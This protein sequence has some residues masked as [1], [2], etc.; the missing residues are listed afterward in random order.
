MENKEIKTQATV[1]PE[2]APDILAKAKANSKLILILSI[3]IFVVLAGALAWFLISQNNAKKSD[4][5]AGEADLYAMKAE[6]SMSAADRQLNDSLALEYYKEA[7][8]MGHKSGNRSKLEVAIR[9]YQKGDYQ[10]ALDYLKDASIGDNLIKAGSYTLM[11]DC[12]VG[13][14]NNA[15]ALKAYDDAIDAADENPAVVPLVLI[16]KANIFRAEKNYEGEYLALK[17][18]LDKYPAY[19]NNT[20][21]DV[22]KYSERAKAAAGK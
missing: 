4:A 8:S 18:I 16:K 3:F 12:Y 22:R 2:Q 21:F 6:Q 9:L 20:A 14:K 17:E 10:G 5:K 13:L 11:G 1:Q 19:D 7:A 15:E